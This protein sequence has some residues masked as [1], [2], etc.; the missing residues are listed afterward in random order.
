MV[1]AL[2]IFGPDKLP[3]LGTPARPG[4]ARVPAGQRRVP[5]DRRA[6]PPDQR[7][8]HSRPRR[9]SSRRRRAPPAGDASDGHAAAADAGAA[10]EPATEPPGAA[11]AGAGQAADGPLEPFWTSRGGRLLHRR[12]C[13]WRGPDPRVGADPAED[14]AGRV[15][16][17]AQGLPRLRP[18]GGRA[19]PRDR[20]FFWLTASTGVDYTPGGRNTHGPTADR[21]PAGGARASSRRSPR[22]TA[23]RRRCARSAG[24]ST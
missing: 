13:A 1:L 8:R 18:E 12:E 4:H 22:R 20:L 15:G 24:A 9:R 23:S 6:E 17:G 16:T 5:L 10:G 2:L 3:D 7:G 21:S 19:S 11:A 14:R